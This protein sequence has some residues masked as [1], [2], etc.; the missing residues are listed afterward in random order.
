VKHGGGKRGERERRDYGGAD[1]NG[2]SVR[3]FDPFQD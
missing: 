3:H 2:G 1:D